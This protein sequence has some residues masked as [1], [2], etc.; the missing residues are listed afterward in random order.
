MKRRA[1]ID[2]LLV[3][4]A[5]RRIEKK[6]DAQQTKAVTENNAPKVQPVDAHS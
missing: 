2:V 6:N 4:D 3:A 1:T 5:K